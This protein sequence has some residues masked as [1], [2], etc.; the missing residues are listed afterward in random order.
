ME[1]LAPCGDEKSFFAAINNGADAIYLGLGNFNARAKSTFFTTENIRKYIEIAHTFGVKVYITTNTLLKDAEIPTFLEF[2]KKCVEARADAFIIQDLAVAKILREAFNDVE[3]HAST[4]MG[5]NN[6]AGAKIAKKLGFARVV[7]AR[8]TKL[9]DIKAI[10]RETGLEIEYF[11]QGALCVSYS[12]N[13]YLSAHEFHKSGNRGECMQ[14]CRL[15]YTASINNKVLGEG[16]LLSPR[17]LSLLENLAELKE[18]GVDSLKIEGRLRRA[19]YVAQSVKSFRHAVDALENTEK[20]DINPE[21]Y[22]LKKVFSRGDFNTR[23]YLDNGV[24]N[25]VINPKIQNHL[26][27]KVGTVERVEK[28]KDLYRV[29][30]KC[31]HPVHSGDGLKF[32]ENNENECASLGVGNVENL[33]NNRYIIYTKNRLKSGLEVYLTLDSENENNL[34]KNQRKITVN[35]HVIA[36][37]NQPL[38]IEFFTTRNNEK[39]AG[40]FVSNFVCERA[41]N[42]PTN[43]A[44]I[45]SQI[46]KLN[47][48][49]FTLNKAEIDAENVF[50]PKS[51]INEARR[52]AISK[53]QQNL[54]NLHEKRIKSAFNHQKYSTMQHFLNSLENLHSTEI[55][56]NIYIVDENSLEK[57]RINSSSQATLGNDF[58][59]SVKNQEDLVA[60]FPTVYQLDLIENAL[61]K[62]RKNYK[63]LALILPVISNGKDYEILSNIIKN[64]PPEITLIINNISG[65][66]FV[67]SGHKI[68]AG[69]SMNV[70]NILDELELKKLGVDAVI[71]SQEII[72]NSPTRYHFTKGHIAL[73]HFA[74]CPFKTLFNN[75]CAQC[76]FSEN[77][78]LTA[79]NG[80]QYFIKR[81]QISQCYFTMYASTKREKNCGNFGNVVDLRFD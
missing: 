72:D 25:D 59:V 45:L 41:K 44:E 36:H 24:P 65:L 61:K 20:I 67:N 5:I 32:L 79:Q 40:K 80:H 3:L 23:A 31:E 33:G 74:H 14:P 19:G 39:I 71:F 57:I 73:M 10:K 50:I 49:F 28:F 51:I 35:A 62:L 21:K 34:L 64:L 12:G 27:V 75:D 8:E 29:W 7:L 4:Q 81:T 2:A 48:T 58:I 9:E 52:E 13:C 78:V 37:E 42:A 47:D 60:L 77:L 18:A 63:N 30:L 26:G 11:V 53:L 69:T 38:E 46:N 70:Y 66:N 17:D 6:V 56:N 76:K 68:I 54:I 1:I 55:T 16:Y 43:E 15:P 22:A